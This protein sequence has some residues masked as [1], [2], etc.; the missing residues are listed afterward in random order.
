MKQLHRAGFPF[1]MVL[2]LALVGCGEGPVT[3]PD[4][5]PPDVAYGKRWWSALNGDQRVAALYG[6][7]A[8][9]EQASAARKEY[10]SL[11]SET[12][13]KVN[14]AAREIYGDGDHESVGAWWQTLDCRQRRIATGDGNTADPTS[15]YCADYPRAER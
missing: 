3:A 7:T 4:D 8:T 15:P 13:R 12:K 1:L 14:A 11:D 2:L 5:P 9:D 10:G 6:E